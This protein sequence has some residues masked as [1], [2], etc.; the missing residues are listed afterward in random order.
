M[1]DVDRIYRITAIKAPDVFDVDTKGLGHGF[2]EELSTLLEL[3]V[4][5]VDDHPPRFDGHQVEIEVERHLERTPNQAN[6]KITNL[7]ERN[8]E[9][10]VDGP[11]KVRLEAG[12]DFTPRLLFIGDLRYASNEHDGTEWITK[13]QLA[14]GA[15]AYANARMNKSYKAGTPVSTI[16]KDVSRAFGV[17]SPQLPKSAQELSTRLATGDVLVGSAADEL[18]RILAPFGFE[19]SFQHE[20]LQIIRTDQALV[21]VARVISEDDGLIGPPEMCPPKIVAPPKAGHRGHGASKRKPRVPKLKLKHTLY[22]EINPGEKIQ[23]QSRSI[24][25]VFRVDVVKHKCDFY[26]G[27]W[28]TEIEATALKDTTSEE[29][30]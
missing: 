30:P 28:I 6:V 20:R 4:V 21:G 17:T 11:V 23:V 24:T 14:D 7:A 15:R 25:G 2:F 16:I 8:R 5:Q 29:T 27:D 3:T 26:G 10:F 1:S 19:W 12:Y 18:T 22:P 9:L 13:L